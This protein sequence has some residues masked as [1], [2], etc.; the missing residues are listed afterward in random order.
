MEHLKGRC[1]FIKFYFFIIHYNSNYLCFST[2]P[3][4]TIIKPDVFREKFNDGTLDT[5]D[6]IFSYSSL[7]HSG[8]GIQ[9][10]DIVRKGT[11][12][13]YTNGNQGIYIESSTKPKRWDE[14][15]ACSFSFPLLP[16]PMHAKSIK[17][18]NIC[19]YVEYFLIQHV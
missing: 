15:S 9:M 1:Y 2:H 14:G 10:H 17:G 11:I 3:L 8:L 12:I 16:S 13:D 5:F 18:E 4:W 7:E 6:V 19:Y